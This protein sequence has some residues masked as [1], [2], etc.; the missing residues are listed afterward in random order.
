MAA[1]PVPGRTPAPVPLLAGFQERRRRSLRPHPL[2]YQPRRR[3]RFSSR[4]GRERDSV[5]VSRPASTWPGELGAR[6]PGNLCCCCCCPGCCCC[7]WQPGSCS[8]Y[9]SNC[10]RVSRGS[11][12]MD[13]TPQHFRFAVDDCRFGL[14]RSSGCDAEPV[15][16]L[17]PQVQ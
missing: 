17:P 10:R 2:S 6:R 8:H 13:G 5:R 3:L 11:S 7:D 16:D 4:T 12:P 1:P 14:P 9:C 15:Y